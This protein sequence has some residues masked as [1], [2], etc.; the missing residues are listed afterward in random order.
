MKEILLDFLSQ[1]LQYFLMFALPALASIAASWLIARA[2]SAWLQFKTEHNGAGWILEQT[3][4][5]A[6]KAAEQA[7]LSGFITDKKTYAIEI[8]EKRLA[9]YGVKIDLDAIDAAIEA[10]VMTEFNK[11]KTTTE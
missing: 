7:K 2:K 3:A 4:S 8:A 10:A 6:V 5:M 9:D 11:A 1:F